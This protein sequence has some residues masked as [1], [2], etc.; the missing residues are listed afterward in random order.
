MNDIT[1]LIAKHISSMAP[2][3]FMVLND[4][5]QTMIIGLL[6]DRNGDVWF[7]EMSRNTGQINPKTKKKIGKC[8]V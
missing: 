8:K 7:I 4:S 6:G 2:N 5:D 3:S 1:D